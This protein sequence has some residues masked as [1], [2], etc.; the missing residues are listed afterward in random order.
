MRPERKC[1]L[2]VK[3][4]A[5]GCRGPSIRECEGNL[6]TITPLQGKRTQDY[7]SMK[8]SRQEAGTLKSFRQAGCRWVSNRQQEL[9]TVGSIHWAIR[10]KAAWQG[11]GK[12]TEAKQQPLSRQA[13]RQ[14][15][16]GSQVEVTL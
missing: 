12:Q 2:A 7:G 6:Q 9:G 11:S 16:L 4:K 15:A 5:P 1:S 14:Q 8:A 3:C 10:K 13:G